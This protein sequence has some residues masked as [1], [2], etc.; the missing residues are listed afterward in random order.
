MDNYYDVVIIGAGPGGMTAALYASRANLKVLV[1][2]TNI[3]GQL[4]DTDI[5]EN[6]PGVGSV[7]GP[8]LADK[9]YKDALRFGAIHEFDLA[10]KVETVGDHKWVYTMM[11][12]NYKTRTVIVATGT[13]YNKLGIQGE[14]KYQGK[15]ISHCFT[16]DAAFFKDRKVA[17]VGGG[18]TA[19]EG[20]IYLT[21][22]TDDVT[23][24]HRRDELRA[25]PINQD[26]IKENSKIN[27]RWNTEIETV[28]GDGTVNSLGVKD[29][30]SKAFKTE[31]FEGLFVAV[32]SSPEIS[33][34]EGLGLEIDDGGY[35]KVNELMET[36]VEGVYAIGDVTTTP[37]KQ[38]STAVGDGSIAGQQVY[39]FLR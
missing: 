39:E 21:Q 17:V 14:D 10:T 22:Y 28:G 33:F 1:L 36:N 35:I 38:I 4:I 27:I 16:C 6:Y 15:G 5:V 18:D 9:M 32:G 13:V 31:N 2:G 25:E 34:L 29:K 11:G 23:L 8:E 24:F 26:R 3:G 19:V 20:A 37:L 30:D 12:N 7:T